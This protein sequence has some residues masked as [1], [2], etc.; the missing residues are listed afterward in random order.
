MND[1]AD[2]ESSYISSNQQP[3]IVKPARNFGVLGLVG[4]LIVLVVIA[5]IGLTIVLT[6]VSGNQMEG[7]N[8]SFNDFM[9]AAK[10]GDLNKMMADVKPGTLSQQDLQ[11]LLA[12]NQAVL[13]KYSNATTDT[14]DT[15]NSP[16]SGSIGGKLR[17]NDNTYSRF[18]SGVEKVNGKW[19]LTSVQLDRLAS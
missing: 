9:Q 7:A 11:N 12:T 15:K 18:Q 8:S 1:T 5:A 19:L 6:P 3:K 17:F 14:F 2:N 10:A 4:G 13:S 16:D